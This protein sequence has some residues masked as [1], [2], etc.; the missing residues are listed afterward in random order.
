MFSSILY[1]YTL[2][3]YVHVYMLR[4]DG[5][6]G[7]S[8]YVVCRPL[9]NTTPYKALQHSTKLIETSIETDEASKPFVNVPKLPV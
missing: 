7:R 2:Y 1:I 9:Y 6:L 3:T 4:Y 8:N 5:L